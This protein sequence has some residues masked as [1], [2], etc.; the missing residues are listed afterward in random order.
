MYTLFFFQTTVSKK[1]MYYNMRVKTLQ[2]N[3]SDLMCRLETEKA[4]LQSNAKKRMQKLYS[5]VKDVCF[6]NTMIVS[7]FLV[8]VTPNTWVAKFIHPDFTFLQ[9]EREVEE[10]PE[11]PSFKENKNPISSVTGDKE[12]NKT[13]EEDLATIAAN[14][15]MYSEKLQQKKEAL[16]KRIVKLQK[17]CY[18]YVDNV[19]CG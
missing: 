15:V 13:K 10:D 17:E 19:W 8:P 3:K 6:V 11:S 14:A 16:L 4:A 2:R 18:E 9:I 12:E 1:K 5:A 7:F